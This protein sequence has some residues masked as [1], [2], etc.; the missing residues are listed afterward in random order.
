MANTDFSGIV[1]INRRLDRLGELK[2]ASVEPL[3]E[4]WEK[5]LVEDNRKGVLAG[6]DRHGIPLQP[7]SYRNSGAGTATK[8]R[9]AF[10][11][12]GTVDRRAWVGRNRLIR[13]AAGRGAFLAF[14]NLP[15]KVYRELTGP[16]LAPRLEASR[17]ITHYF[18]SHGKLSEGRYHA[19]GAWL[20]VL[21]AKGIPFLSAHFRGVN[22]LPK[23]DLAGLRQWGVTRARAA[24]AKWAKILLEK[25]V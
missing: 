2:D 3:L 23:R 11:G 8:A 20:R 10:Q 4:E 13:G 16:P 1:R 5:V 17:V 18:T 19:T 24:V 25:P 9:S 14:G 6:L 22:R 15:S 21:T 12:F 7:T